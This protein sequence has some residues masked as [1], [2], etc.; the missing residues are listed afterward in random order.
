M[1]ENQIKLLKLIE[2]NK[3]SEIEQMVQAGE[4]LNFLTEEGPSFL[5]SALT[6][7]TADTLQ[8]LMDL[9]VEISLKTTNWSKL[10]YAVRFNQVKE[11]QD[12]L[13]SGER[14]DDATE[15]G[16]P[17]LFH[18]LNNEEIFSLLVE[19]G[20]DIN[21]QN[22]FGETVLMKA[23]EREN[24][25]IVLKLVAKNV[26]L[27]KETVFGTTILTQAISKGSEVFAL[28]LASRVKN[29]NLADKT[30]QKTPLMT[31]IDMDMPKVA[32]K[33][34]ENGAD[35]NLKDKD[36]R[37]ALLHALYEE[38]KEVVLALL[39]KGADVSLTDKKGQTPLIYNVLYGSLEM[40]DV[41]IRY[42]VKVDEKDNQGRTALV[43]AIESGGFSHVYNLIAN[44]ADINQTDENNESVFMK[45]VR[46]NKVKTVK[47]MLK[48]GIDV[49]RQ[50]QYGRTALMVAAEKNLDYMTEL[51]LRKGAD[52]Y[53]EDKNGR[54]AWS[55][56][57]SNRS[58]RARAVMKKMQQE[59]QESRLLI[60]RFGTFVMKKKR[61]SNGKQNE[62]N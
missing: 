48:N 30:F 54:D 57:C 11:V 38:Q 44:G 22:K 40:N 31:A 10:E 35:L 43:Y 55:Y 6:F 28:F 41:L 34:I 61:F 12:L 46:T 45:A 15:E 53:L 32:L 3:V 39:K 50:D 52:T 58:H 62:G 7:S 26:D 49:N 56:V 16:E 13:T 19:N 24:W 18:A 25:P 23:L 27:E 4:S 29:L 8:K 5:R 1:T 60:T 17:I 42:G 20:A 59:W 21:A 47:I 2:K 51:L 33:L 36:G 9:G 37:T 14:L